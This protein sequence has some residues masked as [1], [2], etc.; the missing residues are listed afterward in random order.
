MTPIKLSICIPTYNREKYLRQLLESI[1]RQPLNGVEVVVSDN[2]STDGTQNLL[3]EFSGKLEK[4]VTYRWDINAGADRNYLKVVELAQ[5]NY[6]WLMGSDDIVQE[7]AIEK[8]LE[9]LKVDPDIVMTARNITSINLDF[10]ETE[11][12]LATNNRVKKYDFSRRQELLNYMSDCRSLGGLFSYLSS[13]IVKRTAWQSKKFD[14][15]FIGSAYSHVYVLMKIVLSGAKL[16]STPEPLVSFRGGND[17]FKTNLLAR[18]LLDLRGYSRLA[19]ALI[20]DLT[21]KKAFLNVMQCQHKFLSIV[22]MFGS[23]KDKELSI[24]YQNL[25]PIFGISRWK[26]VVAILLQPLSNIAY[27]F[28]YRK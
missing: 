12:F 18:G 21:I 3:K 23:C 22:K 16:Y 20:E 4:L 27:Q 5:G 1:A 17:S 19:D 24:E 9:I 8:V 7:G 10:V 11:N 25:A 6:C 14:D 2:A 15:S 26:V 13:I 28:K